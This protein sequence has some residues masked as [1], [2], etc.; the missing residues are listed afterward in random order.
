MKKLLEIKLQMDTMKCLES[1]KTVSY[2]YILSKCFL[3]HVLIMPV[4]NFVIYHDPEL[5]S[6]LQVL[7]QPDFMP[8]DK[9]LCR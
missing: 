5:N 3:H 7:E 8:F 2:K 1:Y 9:L 4:M 6:N